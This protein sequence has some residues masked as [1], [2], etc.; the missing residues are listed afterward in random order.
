MRFESHFCGAAILSVATPF[1]AKE[2]GLNLSFNDLVQIMPAIILGGIISCDIDTASKASR[3][4]A[5]ASLILTAYWLYIGYYLHPL[6]VWIP[7]GLAKSGKHRGFTHSW[8]LPLGIIFLPLI[9]ELVMFYSDFNIRF[10]H[11]LI[12]K[13]RQAV[14]GYAFGICS[15]LFLDIR[16]IKKIVRFFGGEKSVK[17]LYG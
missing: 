15:H 10:I 16:R 13:Y 6:I 14:N 1:L 17:L 11:D 4:Y 5:R 12:V 2:A 3:Y 9:V 8:L 7:F